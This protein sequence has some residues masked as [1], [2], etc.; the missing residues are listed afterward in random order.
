MTCTIH[1]STSLSVNNITLI[2]N[3][4]RHACRHAC[5]NIRSLSETVGNVRNKQTKT[6]RLLD[7]CRRFSVKCDSQQQIHV[8][9]QLSERQRAVYSTPAFMYI[10]YLCRIVLLTVIFHIC[11]LMSTS[12][13]TYG[14]KN[15]NVC[16]RFETN[17]ITMNYWPTHSFIISFRHK[18]TSCIVYCIVRTETLLHKPPISNMEC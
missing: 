9:R 4:G 6:G 10:I 15:D 8:L 16:D 18:Q 7:M 14:A 13:R 2:S 12:S 3:Y 11:F 17:I 5:I 1:N